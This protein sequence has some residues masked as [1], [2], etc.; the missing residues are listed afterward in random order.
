MLDQGRAWCPQ[1]AFV[2]GLYR[3]WEKASEQS[4]ICKPL[5]SG[6]SELQRKSK[7]KL[8]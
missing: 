8:T 5:K 2:P 7:E 6:Q 3:V 1:E 4:T